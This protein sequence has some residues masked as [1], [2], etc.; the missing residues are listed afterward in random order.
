MAFPQKK[1][2]YLKFLRIKSTPSPSVKIPETV[3]KLTFF[4][5]NCW[6]QDVSYFTVKFNLSVCALEA[7]S[8]HITLV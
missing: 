5:F 8:F 3:N 7:S 4:K 2:N 6:T 1:I